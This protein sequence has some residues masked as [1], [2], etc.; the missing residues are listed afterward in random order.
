MK[1]LIADDDQIIRLVVSAGLKALK[2]EVV[3]CD[4]GLTALKTF[5][6]STFPILITDW[7]MPDMDGIQLTQAVRNVP[8]ETYTYVIMLTGKAT[9]EDYLT[10]VKA[11]VDAFLVKPLDGA[12]LE[13][14]MSIAARI[15]GLQNHAKKLEAIMTV[16]SY[17]KRVRTHDEWV[18]ME[19]YVA[20]EFKALPSHTFCPSCFKEKVEPEMKTLG[21]STDDLGIR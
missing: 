6:E 16:C 21:L 12:M 11:G 15:V 9:R 5:R 1:V 2:H 13:A 19:E 20:D 17:C 8:G 18:N 3:A 4:S 10:A 7:A 14:Q